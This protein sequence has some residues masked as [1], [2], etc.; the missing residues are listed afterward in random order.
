MQNSF[1]FFR[2]KEVINDDFVLDFG[3]DDGEDQ[4][5]S[6]GIK[7]EFKQT[8]QNDNNAGEQEE[9]EEIKKDVNHKSK[10]KD[11]KSHDKKR[12]K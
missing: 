1:I 3:D 2:N 8:E 12:D 6:M 10:N 11:A 4:Q 5:F 7:M 9:Q